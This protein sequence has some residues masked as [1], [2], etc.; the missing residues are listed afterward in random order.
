MRRAYGDIENNTLH[1]RQLRPADVMDRDGVVLLLH[2]IP[3][4]FPHLSHV[5]LDS[6][7]NGRGKGKDW[8]ERTLG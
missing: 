5:W 1:L 4:E 2:D 7:Y 8:I 6:G 3:H